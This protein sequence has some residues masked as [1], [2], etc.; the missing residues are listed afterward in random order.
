[1]AFLK[2]K[3]MAFMGKANAF[4]DMVNTLVTTPLCEEDDVGDFYVDTTEARGA[5]ATARLEY[6]LSTSRA[7]NQKFLFTGHSGSGK[8]TELYKLSE[9]VKNDY[10]V[11]YFSIAEYINYIDVNIVDIIFSMLKN[12]VDT[13][14]TSGVSIDDNILSDIISYWKNEEIITETEID[15][16]KAEAEAAVGLS[17]CKII[18]MKI[19]GIFQQ[20]NSVKKEII[21]HIDK[22]TPQFLKLIN[23]FIRSIERELCKKKL[24]IIVDDLDKLG[25]KE[26]YN[27]FKDH[28]KML[29][30]IE[31][32]V[33]Y[34][35][36]VFM[37]YNPDYRYISMNFDDS[38][39]LSTIMVKK[40][41]DSIFDIGV[42]T[43]H[44]IV[45]KRV[46]ESMFEKGCIDFAIEKSGGSIRAM[47]NLL[48]SAVIGAGLKNKASDDNSHGEIVCMNNL[49]DAYRDYKNEVRR[50]IRKEYIPLL[51]SIHLTKDT[52]NAENNK[53]V[54]ELFNAIAVIEYN[55]DRWCDLN[56]AVL[57]YLIEIHE[58]EG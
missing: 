29:T 6:L 55:C 33:I 11:V 32:N 30:S 36:P 39:I 8:S 52:I 22:T 25:E 26:A 34:T 1:M 27:I 35:F 10:M 46:D 7:H 42:N 37:H 13:I 9:K 47:L 15:D 28:C 49:Y 12:L 53:L 45:A 24:L 16:Y 40:A 2:E 51:K 50:M 31:T 38:V 21:S 48:R 54:M 58:I 17:F 20:S 5:D 56:P 44:E 4:K 43:L 41:D 23:N 3:R 19:K 57:D 18:S 14:E